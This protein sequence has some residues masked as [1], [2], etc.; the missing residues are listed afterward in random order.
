M[1]ALGCR[2]LQVHFE[3]VCSVKGK[4]DK[5]GEGVIRMTSEEVLGVV[6]GDDGGLN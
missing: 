1:I 5:K 3:A 2:S 4:L 6:W